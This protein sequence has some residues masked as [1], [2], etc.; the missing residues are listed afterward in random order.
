MSD[1][2]IEKCLCFTAN[3][4]NSTISISIDGTPSSESN[5]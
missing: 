4:N 5:F 1:I 2:N 3:T